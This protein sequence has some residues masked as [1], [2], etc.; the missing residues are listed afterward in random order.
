VVAMKFMGRPRWTVGVARWITQI[1]EG[2]IEFGVQFLSSTT[3]AVWVQP[4]DSASP[5]SKRGIVFADDG[6]P[7]ALL[8]APGIYAEGRAFDLIADGDTTTVVAEGLIERTARFDLFDV[9]SG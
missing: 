9:S 4:G 6:T 5:Q 1:D 2:G 8:T 7:E 3:R